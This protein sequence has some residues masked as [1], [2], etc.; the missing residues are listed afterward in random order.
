MS[1]VR[2]KPET[3]AVVRDPVT[4]EL[5]TLRAGDEYEHDDPIAKTYAWAFQ[6]DAKSTGR[7]RVRSVRIEQATA[8]PGEMR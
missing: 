1:I 5:V 7:E 3:S 2:V 6:S 4:A 8:N